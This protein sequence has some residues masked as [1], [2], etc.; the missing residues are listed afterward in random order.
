MT[1]K[2]AEQP[3]LVPES[4]ALAPR[5]PEGLSFIERAAMDP[6]VDVDKL[7]RLI[8]LHERA[9]IRNAESAFNAAFAEMMADIP[10]ITEHGST[11]NGKYATLE[12]IIE[13][14]RPVLTKYGFALSHRTEWPDKKTVK[15]VGILM[16]REGHSRSSEFMADADTSGNKNAIQGLGSAVS[17]GRRYTTKDLLNIATR[18]EDNDGAGGHETPE[19]PKGY[20]DWLIDMT[21]T[22]DEG[23]KALEAAWKASKPQHRA[24]LT[25]FNM[26]G[27]EQLKA[28]AAKV[29]S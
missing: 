23:T 28:K 3:V 19:S 1:V 24:Y 29:Q 6:T 22:A 12:D 9:Q 25:K 15:V 26:R 7:E 27:W 8:A 21:A 17:Y 18:G 14:V 13:Q 2:V 16:H 20:D 4:E 10:T 5:Q 11:N